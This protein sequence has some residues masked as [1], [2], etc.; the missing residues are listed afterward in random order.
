[1]FVLV[2]HAH[3]GEKKSWHGPDEDRP[4]STLGYWQARG[5][6]A[7]LDG[8]EL[9]ALFASPTPAAVRRCFRSP[10]RAGCGSTIT[11]CWR[12]THR[13][14][15]CSRCWRRRR[16]TGPCSVPMGRSSTPWL[17]PRAHGTRYGC[18]RRRRQRGAAPG[19][20]TAAPVRPRH[21]STFRPPHPID[22]DPATRP[23]R[24][25]SPCSNGL[26]ARHGVDAVQGTVRLP[27]SARSSRRQE[28]PVDDSGE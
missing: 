6:V 17:N 26:N 5:L 19:S 7:A 16:R 14:T 3:A 22:R 27:S 23:C 1:M 9:R 28:A 2:R 24:R 13:P 21:C 10:R 25:E 12:S 4:L 18:R 11:R 8:I 15:N 20:S